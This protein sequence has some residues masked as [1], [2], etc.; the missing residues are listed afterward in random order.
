MP[1]IQ[2]YTALP[3]RSVSRSRPYSNLAFDPNTSLIVAASSLQAK[4]VLYD[5]DGNAVWTP[6]SADPEV[7]C[8]LSF[9]TFASITGA[10]V[11]EPLCDCS[12]IELISPDLWITMDG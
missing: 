12:T 11:S 2:L 1:D 8:L 10:N 7:H 9:L 6:D 5:E 4:Y 3:S